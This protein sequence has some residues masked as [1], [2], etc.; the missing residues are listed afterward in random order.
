MSFNKSR[1]EVVAVIGTENFNSLKAYLM[2]R[3]YTSYI[4]IHH[5]TPEHYQSRNV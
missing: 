5:T 2:Q 4:L 3:N 1:A